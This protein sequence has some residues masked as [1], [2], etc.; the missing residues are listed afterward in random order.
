MRKLKSSSP[1]ICAEAMHLDVADASEL[2]LCWVALAPGLAASRL[3]MYITIISNQ[4]VTATFPVPLLRPMVVKFSARDHPPRHVIGNQSCYEW[5]LNWDDGWLDY[6]VEY[7]IY[8]PHRVC[9][10]SFPPRAKVFHHIIDNYVCDDPEDYLPGGVVYQNWRNWSL[11]C[12]DWAHLLR[13][14]MFKYRK[15]SLDCKTDMN[16]VLFALRIRALHPKD[17]ASFNYR[18][19]DRTFC[20]LVF[21]LNMCG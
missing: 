18:I 19:K 11:V 1:F 13:D 21:S 14:K 12:T 8:P 9:K 15:L 16:D 20:E 10:C 17:L 5:L 4:S 6:G 7:E 3:C 2:R